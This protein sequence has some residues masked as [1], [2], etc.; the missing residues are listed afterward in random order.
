MNVDGW[1]VGIADGWCLKL[2]SKLIKLYRHQSGQFRKD[3]GPT[4]FD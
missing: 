2:M 4:I 1:Y 3:E